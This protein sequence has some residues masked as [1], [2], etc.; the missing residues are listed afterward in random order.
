MLEFSLGVNDEFSIGEELRGKVLEVGPNYVDVE[1]RSLGDGDM[2]VVR[3]RP[4][5]KE[6]A[7]STDACNERELVGAM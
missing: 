4:P 1:L 5:A 6:T 3:L 2:C 7:E